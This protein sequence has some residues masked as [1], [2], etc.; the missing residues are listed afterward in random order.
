MTAVSAV[1]CSAGNDPARC[2]VGD[3]WAGLDE[4]SARHF[5]EPLPP[6]V[7]QVAAERGIDPHELDHHVEAVH[8][9]EPHDTGY[10]NQVANAA[11]CMASGGCEDPHGQGWRDGLAWLATPTGRRYLDPEDRDTAI[12][13]MENAEWLYNQG[14]AE[15]AKQV[16]WHTQHPGQPCTFDGCTALAWLAEHGGAP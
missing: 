12:P 6:D 1:H 2:C 9:W 11:D 10:A 5:G 3:P 13:Y 4:T 15:A 16:L 14:F 7:I 8:G